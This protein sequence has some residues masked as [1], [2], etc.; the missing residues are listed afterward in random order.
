MLENILV[1]INSRLFG[2]GLT[3]TVLVCGIYLLFRLKP[4]VLLHPLKTL[5]AFKG[6]S[7]GGMPPAKAMCVALAG[8]LGVGNIAGVASAIAVGGSGSIFWMWVSTIAAMPI[9]YAE[10]VVAMKHRRRDSTG[11]YHGGA[12]YYIGDLKESIPSLKKPVKILSSV[13]ALLCLAT[14]LTM[15]C[16]VQ[17][18]AV[19]SSLS[20]FGISPIICG[21]LLS[22]AV[23]AVISGGLKRIA[24]ISVKLIPAM[25]AIYIAMAIYVILSDVISNAASSGISFWSASAVSFNRLF[26]EIFS[27]AFNAK[28]AGGGIVGFLSSNA[29]RIG[30]TRGIVSNEAGCGTAP[31]AH[32]GADNNSPAAQGIWGIF[33]VFADTAVICTLTAFT[34]LI[35][36]KHGVEPTSDG[37]STAINAFGVF[38]PHSE[39]ILAAAIIIF[40]FCTSVCWFYYGR[41]S[42]N[43]LSNKKGF[44]KIYTIIYTAA[45]FVGT[46]APTGAVW[47]FNDLAVSAMTTLNITAVMLY[48]KEISHQTN[49][50]FKKAGKKKKYV[51]KVRI[52][53]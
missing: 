28:A 3:L 6:N 7:E 13:F 23:F 26:S 19:S 34:V 38:I 52:V 12:H 1:F 9:K 21:I 42:L 51:E 11:A 2:P 31:M 24:D 40:A 4:F 25:S 30:V 22:A 46:I 37:M 17:S 36:Q 44:L 27:S 43:F 10:I 20:S 16:A 35:S 33:E 14:S 47:S 15:G 50:Y 32:A 29:V 48:I 5:A 53:W 45:V 49:I 18:N 39:Y 8:T 41:E